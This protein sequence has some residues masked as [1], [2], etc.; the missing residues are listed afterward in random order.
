MSLQEIERRQAS[1]RPVPTPSGLCLFVADP[2]GKDRRIMG[3]IVDVGEGGVGIRTHY[4]LVKGTVVRI[5]GELHGPDYGISL[6]GRARVAN[7]GKERLGAFRVGL[8]FLD[9]AYERASRRAA[10]G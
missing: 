6:R 4:R 10:A 1:R 3:E 8:Q 5:E 2:N 9:I 7:V